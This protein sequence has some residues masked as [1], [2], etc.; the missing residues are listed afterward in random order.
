MQGRLRKGFRSAFFSLLPVR[1]S[2]QPAKQLLWFWLRSDL[3]QI[4]HRPFAID[5]ACGPM[6]NRRFFDVDRYLGFDASESRLSIGRAEHPE[7]TPV[8]AELRELPRLVQQHGRADIV[9]CVQTINTNGDFDPSS[10]LKTVRDLALATASGGS[11][12][13]NFGSAGEPLPVLERAALE[14]LEPLYDRIHVRR[15]GALIRPVPASLFL[16]PLLAVAMWALPP[17]R[18]RFGSRYRKLYLV[19]SG[20]REPASDEPA[21]RIA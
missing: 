11:L 12:L 21:V 14:I 18:H 19:C 9:C 2:E 20:R 8:V 7:E 1:F 16:S 10:A 17:L 4:G 5:A 15:Y 6:Q 13:V 3:R